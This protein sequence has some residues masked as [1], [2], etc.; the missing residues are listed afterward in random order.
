VN[1]NGQD[2]GQF[3]LSDRKQNG[4][5]VCPAG[6]LR[7]GENMV[8]LRIARPARPIDLDIKNKDRR[9]LGL[10]LK[11]LTIAMEE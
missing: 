2:C 9:H 3:M 11:T 6:A 7:S 8:R 4:R 10:G 5:V 1:A